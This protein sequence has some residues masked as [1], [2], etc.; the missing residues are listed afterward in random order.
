MPEAIAISSNETA[1]A[2]N[3]DR[4]RL[5]SIIEKCTALSPDLRP[6]AVEL[7]KLLDQ[8]TALTDHK[9]EI[10]VAQA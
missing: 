8:K 10:E 5:K 3:D 7:Q 6:D 1:T 9:S 4:H 2:I